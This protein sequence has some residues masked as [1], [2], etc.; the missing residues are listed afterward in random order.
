MAFT[1]YSE[2]DGLGLG[3]LVRRGDVSAPELVEE[4]IARIERQNPVLNAVVH[5]AYDAA[6]RASPRHGGDP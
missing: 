1:E 3:E 5:K 4:A 6:R 2:Y